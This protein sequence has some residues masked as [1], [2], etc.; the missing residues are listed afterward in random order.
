MLRARVGKR[1]DLLRGGWLRRPGELIPSM[2][3]PWK[4]RVLMATI[5]RLSV[6]DYL[7]SLCLLVEVLVRLVPANNA[8]GSHAY[9]DP[10]IGLTG[11]HRNVL[12]ILF[13]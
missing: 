5:P 8:I 1:M 10:L 3:K 11:L 2:L 7:T 6:K 9:V 12:C 4:L 13:I